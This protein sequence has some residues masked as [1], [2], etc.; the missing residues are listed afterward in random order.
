M[1]GAV[2]LNTPRLVE[3]QNQ[4][5]VW[6]WQ[7][8]EP[9]GDSVPNQA[10]ASAGA[11]VF[12]LRFP[13]QYADAET[14]TNYNN[15]RDYAPN[16]GRYVQ[17]DPIGLVAGLNT[18]AYVDGMPIQRIDPNGKTGFGFTFGGML[19]AGAGGTAL[20]G[21]ANA[22]GGFFWGGSQ[23]FNSSWLSN[24][25][26][27]ASIY[28]E[29]DPVPSEQI[30]GLVGGLG[31]GAFFTNAKCVADLKGPFRMTNINLPLISIQWG[32]SG[33]IWQWGF[34]VG[35]SWAVASVSRYTVTTT[36]PSDA[37]ECPCH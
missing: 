6:T 7:Q 12:N 20:G 23:G 21:Q 9:F 24:L 1:S 32:S 11:F 31:V 25:G 10:P 4:N 28:H 19:E 2:Y 16:G 26:G 3:D 36:V 5:P 34:G 30:I 22:G 13:G 35:K 33:G 37:Q 14:N 18:Y 15:A 29:S 17:S 8:G 27:L